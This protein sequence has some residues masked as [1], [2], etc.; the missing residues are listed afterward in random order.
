MKWLI[1]GAA[2]CVVGIGSASAQPPPPPTYA[3]IPPPRAEVIPPPPGGRDGLGAGTLALGR[4]P[5][6]VEAR[7]LC[8]EPAGIPPL[9][10]RPL[11]LGATRRT[12]DLA[13][14]ALG[15]DVVE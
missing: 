6:R 8:P 7:P 14:R 15:I 3:P 12:V 2:V 11:D 1:V 13:S 5:L 9:R 4:L 10:R